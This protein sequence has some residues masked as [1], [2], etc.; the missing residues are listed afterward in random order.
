[1]V[2]NKTLF[3]SVIIILN[4]Y[5]VSCENTD[6]V[7]YGKLKTNGEHEETAL[8]L[9]KNSDDKSDYYKF[10][11]PY[12]LE[13]RSHPVFLKAEI[14]EITGTHFFTMHLAEAPPR[15]IEF[16]SD[17]PSKAL[18]FFTVKE[19]LSIEGFSITQSS[20]VTGPE[21]SLAEGTKDISP[22]LKVWII[23]STEYFEGYKKEKGIL[24]QSE[25][26]R[27]TADAK[28]EIFAFNVK[29][30]FSDKNPDKITIS[31]ENRALSRHDDNK[32]LLDFYSKD[33][34]KSV[35]IFP[36][37]DIINITS[38]D[39]DA[40]FHVVPDKIRFSVSPLI[41][42]SVPEVNAVSVFRFSGG[43][44]H[45][46]HT[47]IE[48]DFN[49]MLDYGMENWRNEN[50][51]IFS[52][53]VFPEFLLIDTIDYR[54]QNAMFKR[55]AFFVEKP[56]TA[57]TLLTDS[58]ME[59]LH[60]WNAHDYR[61]EDLSDFFNLAEKTGFILSD[62]EELLKLLLLENNAIRKTTGTEFQPAGGGILSISR[63]SSSFLRKVFIS[64]EGYH[65]VFFSSKEFR[66]KCESIWDQASD[67]VKTF[68]KIFLAHKYYDITNKY[69]VVNEFM[70]YNLQQTPEKG[71]EY[72]FEYIIPALLD[73][74]PSRK[75]LLENIKENYRE[76]FF[77]ISGKLADA[78]YETTAL[79]PGNLLFIET[80]P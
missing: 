44:S 42:R 41:E 32:V 53:S 80:S 3:A 54:F 13:N 61:A 14:P 22:L 28:N 55:L 33:N 50:Y 57:G 15:S 18:L 12:R 76:E 38:A 64:H 73:N 6:G 58:E 59:K 36:V 8:R 49:S 77:E 19:S 30:S 52:W 70:A 63:E 1:M 11:K 62:E 31:L 69:L 72:F 29:N 75:E 16:T 56:G 66:E 35:K 25:N 17:E 21:K 71:K 46:L 24:Y 5:L 43:K 27:R 23:S 37:K 60:G 4:I 45:P 2:M 10:K 51:E 79:P 40:I 48:A 78:L 67:E 39:L 74:Y 65:G 68:W 7:F 9:E 26:F 47:A 20:E 34:N